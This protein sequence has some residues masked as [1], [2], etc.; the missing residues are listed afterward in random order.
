MVVAHMGRWALVPLRVGAI[1]LT[2][3][4]ASETP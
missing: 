4:I 1:D 2:S 3:A